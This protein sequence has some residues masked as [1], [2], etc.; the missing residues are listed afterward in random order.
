MTNKIAINEFDKNLKS[1]DMLEN[2][3]HTLSEL[4]SI[5]HIP[6]KISVVLGSTKLKVSDLLN[7]GKGDIIA[8]DRIVGEAIDI[9]ANNRLV[10]RGEIVVID[11]QLGVTMTEIVGSEKE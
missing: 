7:L 11:E 4:S 5:A 10:A 6:I 3:S 2:K 1:E 8:I 9:Y